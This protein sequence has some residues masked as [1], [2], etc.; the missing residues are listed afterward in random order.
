MVSPVEGIPSLEIISIVDSMF[1]A[2]FD[3]WFNAWF[4]AMFKDGNFVK[5]VT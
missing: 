4:E 2:M 1:D 3:A 5:R